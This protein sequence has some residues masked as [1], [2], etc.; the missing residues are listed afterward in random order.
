M[1]QKYSYVFTGIVK[2]EG[3]VKIDLGDGTTPFQAGPQ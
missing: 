2:Q 1:I 3:T